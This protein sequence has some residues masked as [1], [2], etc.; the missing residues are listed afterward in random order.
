MAETQQAATHTPP[1]T[2][3][4]SAPTSKNPFKKIVSYLQAQATN[5]ANDRFEGPSYLTPRGKEPQQKY[6]YNHDRRKSRTTEM[7]RS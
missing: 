1:A 3:P 4:S 6:N 2:A 7:E 5:A